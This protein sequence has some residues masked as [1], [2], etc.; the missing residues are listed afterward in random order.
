MSLQHIVLFS[1]HQ[2]LSLEDEG[3]MRPQVKAWPE[4]I[5]G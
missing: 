3:D 1:F 5:G 4:V 2:D